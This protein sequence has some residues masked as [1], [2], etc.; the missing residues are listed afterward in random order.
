MKKLL[1]SIL[2]LWL[3]VTTYAQ[4]P[5]LINYQGV[6]L[7]ASNSPIANQSIAIRATIHTGTP[8]GTVQYSEERTLSTDASGLFNFQVG[9][10]GATN[11]LGSITGVTWSAAPKYLQVEMDPAGGSN[12]TDMGTQQLASVPYALNSKSASSLTV[13][14]VVNLS[15]INTTGATTNQVLQFNGTNWAPANVTLTPFTLP[16]SGSNANIESF[17]VNNTVM[18]GRA[19][20]GKA[21]ASHTSSIGVLG[22]ATNTNLLGTGVEGRAFVSTAI[23]VKGSNGDGVA[24]KG[25]HSPSLG[26]SMAA[27]LGESLSGYGKG[28]E[29]IANDATGT[30][31]FGQSTNGYGVRGYS[32]NL[33]GVQGQTLDGTAVKAISTSIN[34]KALEVVGNVKISG[35]NTNPSEGAVLTSDASGN[36]VWKPKKVAF[37]AIGVTSNQPSGVITTLFLDNEVFDSGNDFNVQSAATDK[38]TF[39]A[40]VSGVYHFD[41]HVLLILN[42]TT[43][44]IS[45]SSLSIMVNGSNYYNVEGNQPFNITNQSQVDLQSGATIMLSAGDKVKVTIY[46]SNALGLTA[47]QHSARFNGHLVFAN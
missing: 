42:S 7:N 19:I 46:Q 13:D 20:V 9:S 36:A 6:A 16:F 22:E 4:A 30:G 2:I 32:E 24:V 26:S 34:G 15:N 45:S 29:G 27:V 41:A 21:S 17:V 31:V 40:P 23:G 12:F 43:T 8:N 28:V 3:Y 10:S 1:S 14:A 35:G 37:A 18:G 5:N 38:S 39:I 25:A 11:T 47:Q 33:V 44:N